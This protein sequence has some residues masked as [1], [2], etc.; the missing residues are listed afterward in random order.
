M[1]SKNYADGNKL[2]LQRVKEG[3]ALFFAIE[4]MEKIEKLIKQ[5]KTE[6]DQEQKDYDNSV[7]EDD[8]AVGYI[9]GLELKIQ[10]LQ[11]LIKK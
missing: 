1:R 2:H 3:Q 7:Q 6:M 8:F 11:D 5:T 9:R 10:D 4:L